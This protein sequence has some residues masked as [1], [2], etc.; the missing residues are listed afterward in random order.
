VVPG[1]EWFE[2]DGVHFEDGSR[3]PLDA[4]VAA[5]GFRCRLDRFLDG[6]AEVTDDRGY[7]R[8]FGREAALPGLYFVGYANPVSGALRE[9]R[10]EAKRVAQRIAATAP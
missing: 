6:A 8:R 5:T 3:R 9:I 1:I 2:A 10:L 7:P 4:V